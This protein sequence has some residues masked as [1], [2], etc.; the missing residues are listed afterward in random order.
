MTCRRFCRYGWIAVTLIF[1]A[2]LAVPSASAQ[3]G[4]GEAAL[5][6]TATLTKDLFQPDSRYDDSLFVIVEDEEGNRV[7]ADLEVEVGGGPVVLYNAAGEEVDQSASDPLSGEATGGVASFGLATKKRNMEDGDDFF[8]LV[9]AKAKD[10]PEITGKTLVQGDLGSGFET[11]FNSDRVS[12]EVFIGA[13]MSRSY[14]ENGENTGFDET[15]AV[16]RFRAD[17]LR[18]LRNRQGHY[19]G[20]LHTGFELQFSSFPPTGTEPAESETG[21]EGDFGTYADAYTGSISVIFQPRGELWADYSQSSRNRD[22]D[23]RYD[24]FRHGFTARVGVTSR[25][26]KDS[27]GDTD[28]LHYRAGYIFTHHQTR[29]A[30][31]EADIINVFPIRFVEISVAQYE[32]IF[33]KQDDTR[34]IVEAGLRLPGLGNNAVPFYGGIYLNAGEGQDDFR[35]FAGFLFQLDRIVR[36]F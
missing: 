30:T 31:A 29:A 28:I 25:D 18:L 10:N 19:R 3:E 7:V 24:A 2:L 22:P 21:D 20:S 11:S 32:E 36:A 9:R 1:V 27:N 17:T 8:I 5:K 15:S 16:A 33:N 26:G 14:D 6:V 13:T 12:S 4:V 35:V 34:L 23:L